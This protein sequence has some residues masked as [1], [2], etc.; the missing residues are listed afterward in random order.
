MEVVG[1][2]MGVLNLDVGGD[3]GGWLVLGVVEGGVRVLRGLRV[4][5]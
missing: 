3:I 2:G 4:G 5:I 1:K